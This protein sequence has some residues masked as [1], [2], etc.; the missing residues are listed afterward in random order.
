MVDSFVKALQTTYPLP[1]VVSGGLFGAG[2]VTPVFGDFTGNITAVALATNTPFMAIQIGSALLLHGRIKMSASADLA[3]ATFSLQ[4]P[5]SLAGQIADVAGGAG[6]LM[7]GAAKTITVGTP[8]QPNGWT[9]ATR[10]TVFTINSWDG[11]GAIVDA[12]VDVQMTFILTGV[13]AIT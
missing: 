9:S 3:G 6:L 1:G 8:A 2:E 4:L 7:N 5:A 11:P 13:G 10:K 12:I